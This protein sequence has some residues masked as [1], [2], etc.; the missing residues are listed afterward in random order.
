MGRKPKETRGTRNPIVG[1][2]VK[3]DVRLP[4]EVVAILDEQA[5]RLG[6][7]KN[8]YITMAIC[9]QIGD[10]SRFV[11]SKKRR[12]TI[13]RDVAALFQKTVGAARRAP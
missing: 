2:R 13:L 1:D 4:G 11:A 8:A 12:L 10:L 5:A 6:L 9:R 3:T 7:T